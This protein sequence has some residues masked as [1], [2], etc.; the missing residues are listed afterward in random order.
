M[1]KTTQ[2]HILFKM[3]FLQMGKSNSEI[4]KKLNSIKKCK[5]AQNNE[6]H[7]DKIK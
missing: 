4:T 1:F 5:H 3:Y 7:I 6:L 2:V